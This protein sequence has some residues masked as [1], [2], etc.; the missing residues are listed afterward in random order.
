M[1]NTYTGFGLDP[2]PLNPRHR[3]G[4][5]RLVFASRAEERPRRRRMRRCPSRMPMVQPKGPEWS[6]WMVG[7]ST[8]NSLQDTYPDDLR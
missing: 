3:L 2:A 1:P 8:A 4:Q 5:Q 6:E 7:K